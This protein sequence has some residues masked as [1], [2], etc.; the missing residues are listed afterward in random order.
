MLDVQ[1]RS[2][3][4]GWQDSRNDYNNSNRIANAMT[5]HLNLMRTHE[6]QCDC[7]WSCVTSTLWT[8]CIMIHVHVFVT[9]YFHTW[10]MNIL[11]SLLKHFCIAGVI[12]SLEALHKLRRQVWGFLTQLPQVDIWPSPFPSASLVYVVYDCPPLGLTQVKL[13][14]PVIVY[15]RDLSNLASEAKAESI[16][17]LKSHGIFWNLIPFSI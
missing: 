13:Y 5:R 8:L 7:L 1:R 17:F 6:I 16:D 12:L 4:W 3:I 15:R 10:F 14:G 2:V 9:H 11:I